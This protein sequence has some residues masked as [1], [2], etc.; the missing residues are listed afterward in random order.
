MVYLVVVRLNTNFANLLELIEN[1][2][3]INREE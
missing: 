3:L 1:N 2:N